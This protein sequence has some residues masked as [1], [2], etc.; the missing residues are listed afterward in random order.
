MNKQEM[1]ER[2]KVIEDEAKQIR[3][4]LEKPESVVWKPVYNEIYY[5]IE[6]N[7]EIGAVVWKDDKLDEERYTYGNCY[8]IGQEAI[9]A[10]DTK[11]ILTDLQRMAD[12]AN[13]KRM[14][15]TD[16]VDTPAYGVCFW[17]KTSKLGVDALL[18]S[19]EIGNNAC[20]KTVES[21][22]KALGILIEKY[23]EERV[24]MALSGV[25]R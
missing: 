18:F 10:R 7:G 23:T 15:C 24:K 3:A 20:F 25:W 1:V 22:I 19:K 6:H 21:A 17:L 8:Y 9:D 12:E 2:L 16:W 11:I 14:R 13:E 4:K 5:F